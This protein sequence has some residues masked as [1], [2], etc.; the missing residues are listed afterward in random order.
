MQ[1]IKSRM[2]S[3][4]KYNCDTLVIQK[5]KELDFE[6]WLVAS[7]YIGLSSNA[8]HNIKMKGEEIMSASVYIFERK[9]ELGFYQNDMKCESV[10]EFMGWAAL[11]FVMNTAY[12]NFEVEGTAVL[13]S[14]EDTGRVLTT[15]KEYYDCCMED[16]EHRKNNPFG[17]EKYQYIYRV[18][19]EFFDALV[20][21]EE[22]REWSECY[23]R[24]GQKCWLREQILDFKKKLNK[25]DFDNNYYYVIDSY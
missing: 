12:F 18:G 24:R 25:L 2:F 19:K 4:R 20:S 17:L 14:D 7:L 11:D 10:F 13:S 9:K 5:T 15:T 21:R 23:C 22:Y 3:Q 8:Q 16:R 6:R 1:R